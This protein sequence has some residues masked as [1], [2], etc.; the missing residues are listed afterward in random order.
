[1]GGHLTLNTEP[2]ASIYTGA[3]ELGSGILSVA[4]DSAAGFAFSN[5]PGI[6]IQTPLLGGG[7]RGTS[8]FLVKNDYSEG[9]GEE[10]A[11]EV[12]SE[13]EEDNGQGGV[14]AFEELADGQGPVKIDRSSANKI[15]VENVDRRLDDDV[16]MQADGEA[17]G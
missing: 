7:G 13:K 8:S 2:L 1:M 9:S 3:P 16:V 10:S 12:K 4:P 11:A 17:K 15:D 14:N 5:R 6:L